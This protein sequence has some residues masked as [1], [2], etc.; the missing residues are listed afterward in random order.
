MKYPTM[1]LFAS[2]LVVS[3]QPQFAFTNFAGL[4]GGSG[5]RDGTWTNA[6]FA[7]PFSLTRD[8]AD[9]MYLGDYYNNSIRMITPGSLVTTLA[10]G[11]P[12]YNR[13]DGVAM[14][15]LGNL[16]VADQDNNDIRKITNGVVSV[17]AGT[18]GSGTLGTND[19]TGA[20]AKFYKPTGLALDAGGNLYVAD[21]YNHLIRKVTPG[22]VVT[23][24]AGLGKAGGGGYPGTNDGVGSAARFNF[25][26]CVTV[27]SATNLFVADTSNNTIRKMTPSGAD[28]TVTTFAGAAGQ[29]GTNDG[30]GIAARFNT[31]RGLAFDSAGNLFVADSNNHTIRMIT[32]DGTVT[33]I[34]GSP[35]VTG[36]KGGTNGAARFYGPRGLLFDSAGNLFVTDAGNYRISKGV[37]LDGAGVPPAFVAVN[38]AGGLFNVQV[39]NYAPGS[40]VVI[41]VS[42]NLAAWSPV[43]TNTAGSIDYSDSI[44]GEGPRFYRAYLKP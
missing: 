40:E 6:W 43:A 31:P 19:G 35:G 42:S 4:I 34:A 11:S 36:S 39:T 44:A 28:W 17:F 25:P 41:E 18:A 23:T 16:Y 1:V 29:S 3:G 8:G 38:A 14:D 27:D 26:S 9:T 7:G 5:S 21:R 30:V 2:A 37:L 32:P 15:S 20:A 12:S 22:A 33:T 10:G 24:L 13:P